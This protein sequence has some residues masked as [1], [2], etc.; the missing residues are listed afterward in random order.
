MPTAFG[1]VDCNLKFKCTI[2]MPKLQVY[3]ILLLFHT[4]LNM[5]LCLDPT[6]KRRGSGDVRLIP[7]ASLT[8]IISGENFPSANHIAE[9]AIRSATP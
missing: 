1:A 8:L 3:F 4:T 2:Q 9:N 5:V 6:S 7:W